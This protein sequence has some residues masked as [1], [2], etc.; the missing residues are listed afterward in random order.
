MASR[1]WII[2]VLGFVLIF[3]SRADFFGLL[4]VD[5]VATVMI[6]GDWWLGAVMMNPG[7]LILGAVAFLF[8]SGRWPEGDMRLRDVPLF[9]TWV[10]LGCLLSFSYLNSPYYSDRLTDPVRIAYQLYRYCWKPTLYYVL[11]ALIV[12]RDVDRAR[13]LM[14]VVLALGCFTAF[15]TVATYVIGGRA[16]A[17]LIDEKNKFAGAL[18]APATACL[19]L[20][21]AA[22]AGRAR[23]LLTVGLGI[24]GVGLV[25]AGSR[26]AM[27]AAGVAAIVL[28]VSLARFAGG[29]RRLFRLVGWAAAAVVVVLL[30]VPDIGRFAG[31][32]QLAELSQGS[33]VNT[34]TWRMELRWPHFWKIILEHPWV[35]VGTDRDY[36]LGESM[37]TPHNGYLSLALHH[38][39]PVAILMVFFGLRSAM[40]AWRTFL[41]RGPT[42]PR[43]LALGVSAA[44]IGL[45]TH[46][47][48]ESTLTQPYVEKL[49]WVLGGLA[50]VSAMLGKDAPAR[51]EPTT[52]TAQSR[53]RRRRGGS[54]PIRPIAPAPEQT[55]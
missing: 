5:L 54:I 23:T 41:R 30:V 11:T 13:K 48:V 14:I 25:A 7:D 35:G 44:I 12:G 1:A 3:T 15:S 45:M 33:D 47:I 20:L 10:L 52:A 39:L 32:R 42:A 8:L 49:F 24:L 38:G 4:I 18:I 21:L 19:A 9:K 34:L 55:N 43:L 6:R 53:T 2:P 16:G 37:N 31:A 51:V 40:H 27:V 50:S 46:N 26:G 22:P 36:S 17:D 29:R 28:M